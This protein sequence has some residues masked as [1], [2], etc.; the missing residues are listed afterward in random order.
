MLSRW[1]PNVAHTLHSWIPN[2]EG[3]G[4]YTAMPPVAT[5]GGTATTTARNIV[6]AAEAAAEA[7]AEELQWKNYISI[8]R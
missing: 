8:L 6:S 1:Y 3:M 4:M 7:A 5:A 2:K